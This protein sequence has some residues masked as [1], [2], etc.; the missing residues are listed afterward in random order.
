MHIDKPST[1]KSEDRFQRYEFS[2]RI[3]SIIA[4]PK[5][6]KSLIVGLYGKWGEGKTSVMN[7]VQQELP[8]DTVVVNFNPWMFSDEQHLLKSFFHF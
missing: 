8:E 7:F 3:A 1:I 5:I 2:N 4:T 6:D